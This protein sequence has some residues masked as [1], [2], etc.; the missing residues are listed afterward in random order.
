MKKLITGD[1]DWTGSLEYSDC[2]SGLIHED[3]HQGVRCSPE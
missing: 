3:W 2:H 1:G